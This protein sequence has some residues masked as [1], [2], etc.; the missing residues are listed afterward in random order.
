MRQLTKKSTRS[1]ALA[2]PINHGVKPVGFA[3]RLRVMALQIRDKYRMLN[4]STSEVAA[5]NVCREA[6]SASP[7]APLRSTGADLF[8]LYVQRTH[9]YYCYFARRSK[10]AIRGAFQAG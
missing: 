6:Q 4:F 3:R 5:R 10:R 7:S 2:W 9:C 1:A 8:F